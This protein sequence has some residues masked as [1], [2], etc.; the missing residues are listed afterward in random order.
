MVLIIER[1]TYTCITFQICIRSTIGNGRLLYTAGLIIV[2]DKGRLA[3]ITRYSS[4]VFIIEIVL[5]IDNK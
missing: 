5:T 3:L 2:E 4:G 1:L